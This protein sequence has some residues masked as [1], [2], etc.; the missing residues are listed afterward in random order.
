MRTTQAVT[1]PNT[2]ALRIPAAGCALGTHLPSRCFCPP[3][4]ASQGNPAAF[5]HPFP[6]GQCVLTDWGTGMSKRA[7]SFLREGRPA[8]LR[9]ERKVCLLLGSRLEGSHWHQTRTLRMWAPGHTAA[10]SDLHSLPSSCLSPNCS[11][12]GGGGEILFSWAL[13]SPSNQTDSKRGGRDSDLNSGRPLWHQS[14]ER[15]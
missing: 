8:F 2:R 6:R 10:A 13:S 9:L 15:I 5:P 1:A 4:G 7:T 3:E 11:E 14:G 12:P